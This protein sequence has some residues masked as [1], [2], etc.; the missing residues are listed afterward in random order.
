MGL[1]MSYTEN[2]APR[3]VVKEKKDKYKDVVITDID[4]SQPANF[5]TINNGG[6]LLPSSNEVP[7]HVSQLNSSRL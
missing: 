4:Q 5:D 7:E 3:V 6:T 2:S 1:S